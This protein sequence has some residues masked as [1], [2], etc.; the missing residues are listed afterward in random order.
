MEG[1]KAPSSFASEN[2]TSEE[3]TQ[4]GTSRSNGRGGGRRSRFAVIALLLGLAMILTQALGAATAL[5][6][7]RDRDGWFTSDTTKATRDRTSS[8]PSGT[9]TWG[10]GTGGSTSTAEGDATTT[11]SLNVDLDQY[12]NL[13]AEWQNGDLNGSNS[14]YAEGDVVPFRLAI[15]GLGAGTHTI[16]INYDFTSGGH[17]AYDFLATW[18]ATESPGL[19][20][21]GGGAVSSMCPSLGSA[22]T[23]AFPTDPFEPGD[24]TRA[25]LTVAGAEAFSGVSRS[26]TMY[27]GTID[28]ITAPSHEGPVAGNSTGDVLVTFTSSADAVLLAW[29][30]HIAQSAYW[31]TTGGA[32]NGASVING[33]PWHMRTQQLDGSGNRNQDR[34]IQPSAIQSLPSLDVRKTA[35]ST[36]VA[37]GETFTYTVTVS[38]TGSRSASPVVVSDDLDDSLTSVSATYD[39]DPGSGQ[40]GTCDVGAGNT[41]T[42]AGISLAAGDAD[43][44][45]PEDD[46][47]SVSITA[48][49]PTQ[50]CPTLLNTA[51]ARVGSGAPVSSNQV[52]VMVVGCAVDLGL[53]KDSDVVVDAEPGDAATFIIVVTNNGSVAAHDVVVTDTVPDGLDIDGATFAG[54]SNGSGACDISGQSVTCD[55]GSLA[56]G[57]SVTVTIGVTVTVGACPSVTNMAKVTASNETGSQ[58]DNYDS[59][60]FDVNCG[61][62]LRLEKSADAQNVSPGDAVTFTIQ[63][64]N[65]GQAEATNVHVTDSM[66]AGATIDGATFTGGSNGPGTCTVSG[67]S[68]DCDLGTLGA[69]QS[70]TVIVVVTV[71]A[72]ACPSITND[73][74]VSA[75]N[76]T[77]SVDDNSDSVTV[78]VTC[79]TSPPPPPSSPPPAAPLGIRIIKDGPAL[80]HVGDTITYTFD[81]SLTTSTPLTDVTLTDPICSAAPALASKNGGDQDEW[82]EPAES[83]R[84][85]CTH[86]VSASDPDPLPNT[87]T[88]RG[89]DSRGRSTSDTDD[90]VVD[91]IHP[92]IRIVKTANPPSIAPGETVTYTFTVTNVGDVALFGVSVDDDKLGHICDIPRLDVGETRICTKDFTAGEGNLGPL[93]N[94]GVAEGKDVTGYPVRDR[95][96]AEVDVVL[97]VTVTPA[98]TTAPPGPEIAFTGSDVLPL[99]GIAVVLLVVGAGLIHLGR[100]REDGSRT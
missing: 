32:D 28:G 70:A 95:D 71:D 51:S 36:Q 37:P 45:P 53:T 34:S 84:Y 23:E 86:G 56:A 97:A 72:A 17:E 55:I 8:P 93:E 98:I 35:S 42:C 89:T 33:A 3:A 91:I 2:R 7:T 74:S 6:G 99:A 52:T 79:P 1:A 46:T 68:I 5:A 4:M 41:I 18:N 38:N 48:T 57:A 16:H 24:P 65:D 82:L 60:S 62:N 88:V 21:P 50:S 22:D 26:L 29:G 76:E 49:A 92:A 25:G 81:V 15:E 27:G 63:V 13:D 61:V 85:T 14:A 58:H 69:G 75:D 31:K 47:V 64:T 94:V 73:A 90:H 20:D 19:C 77:G 80:A 12:A 44:V 39:V 83:W 30:G 100:R 59:A 10:D 66:P 87:A 9:T 40:D 78:G 54:G 96:N 67:Q 11:T 43:V